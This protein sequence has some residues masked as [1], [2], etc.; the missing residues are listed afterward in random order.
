MEL[1]KQVAAESLRAA[2][3][4]SEAGRIPKSCVPYTEAMVQLVETM[5][6]MN[7]A[8][9]LFPRGEITPETYDML[10]T[11]ALGIA[12]KIREAGNKRREELGLRKGGEN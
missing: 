6:R 7:A 10:E 9:Q 3:E 11:E 8:V 12:E 1:S 4:Q 5:H 2:K